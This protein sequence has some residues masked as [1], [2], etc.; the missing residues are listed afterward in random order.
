[1]RTRRLAEARYHRDRMDPRDDPRI[2]RRRFTTGGEEY[3][4]CANDVRPKVQAWVEVDPP[5]HSR[6]G[7]LT[8]LNPVEWLLYAAACDLVRMHPAAEVEWTAAA[9]V[10]C[11]GARLRGFIYRPGFLAAPAAAHAFDCRPLGRR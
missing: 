8:A 5:D 2:F 3:L 9:H 11:E 7:A 4:V 6:R 1:M 10:V